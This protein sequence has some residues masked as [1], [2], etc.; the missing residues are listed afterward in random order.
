MFW[1][2]L[3][4]VLIRYYW[5]AQKCVDQAGFELTEVSV[6]LWLTNIEIKGVDYYA[7]PHLIILRKGLLFMWAPQLG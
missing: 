1:F 2:G 5:L 3:E 6:W 4:T 7:W